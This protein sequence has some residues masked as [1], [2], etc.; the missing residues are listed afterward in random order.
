MPYLAMER[1]DSRALVWESRKC[2]EKQRSPWICHRSAS[3]G[4]I[5][6]VPGRG[7][8]VEIRVRVW[9]GRDQM[10][11]KLGLGFGESLGWVH[12]CI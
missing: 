3:I 7:D 4:R 5:F 2:A 12:A 8:S 9:N 10:R 1:A 11:S 6:G